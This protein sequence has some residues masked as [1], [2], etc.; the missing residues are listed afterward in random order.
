MFEWLNNNNN[1][2]NNN[3]ADSAFTLIMPVLIEKSGTDL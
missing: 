1:N 2:N 3:D